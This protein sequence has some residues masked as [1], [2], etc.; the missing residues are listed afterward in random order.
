MEIKFWSTCHLNAEVN[1]GKNVNYLE[2]YDIK[3]MN[4]TT[5]LLI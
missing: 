5:D 3:M 1:Q 4:S 2:A